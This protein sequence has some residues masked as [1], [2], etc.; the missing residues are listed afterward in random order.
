MKITRKVLTLVVAVLSLASAGIATAAEKAKPE[1]NSTME[2]H[3]QKVVYHI[4]DAQVADMALHNIQNHINAVGADKVEIAVVTH[5]KG[6]D[7]LLDDWKDANGKNFDDMVQSLASQGV[8]FMVCNNTLQARKI[9]KEK[10]N[11]NATIVPSGVATLGE[12]Q[13]RGYVYIKP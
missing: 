5:G 2:Y 6:I 10:V 11:L 13:M 7:F 8:K 12:L 9:S 1:N 4:N 3:K